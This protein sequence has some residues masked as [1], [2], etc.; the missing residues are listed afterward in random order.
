MQSL[1]SEKYV[2]PYNNHTIRIL[3]DIDIDKRLNISTTPE[4]SFVPLCNQTIH[5]QS[6][7]DLLS[8]I[9]L[10]VL[11][12][13]IN[14]LAYYIPFCVCL[15]GKMFLRVIL[16]CC[17]FLFFFLLKPSSYFIFSSI[18]LYGNTTLC[19]SIHLLM[20]VWI[21]SSFFPL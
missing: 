19:L 14:G 9:S 16:F 4:S 12:F 15:L 3:I 11:E 10:S 18:L 1:N 5:P 13:H 7:N 17:C 8:I 21:V 2:Y 6:I 20:N